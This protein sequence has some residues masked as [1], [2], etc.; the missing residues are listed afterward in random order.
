MSAVAEEITIKDG[1]GPVEQVRIPIPEGG[2][3]VV[4]T[5]DNG[6]GKSESL[7]AVESLLGKKNRLSKRDGALGSGTVEGLGVTLRVGVNVRRSGE[8]GFSTLDDEFSLTD[9][10]DPKEKDPAAADGRRIKAFVRAAD[11]DPDPSL[12][13]ELVGG[14]ETFLQLVSP[15]TI[16]K[17]DLVEMAA[18]IKRDLEAKARDFES[19]AKNEADHAKAIRDSIKD[20][21]L[22]NNPGE[23]INL[24]SLYQEAMQKKTQLEFS[25][26][27]AR[28]A[29]AKAEEARAKLAEAEKNVRRP[30]S[31]IST[32]HEEVSKEIVAMDN[33]IES[34]QKQLEEVTAKRKERNRDA[35]SLLQQLTDAATLEASLA[36]WKQSIDQA[37]NLES[38]TPEELKA[39]TDEIASIEVDIKSSGI[40]ER[41]I[42]QAKQADQ[43]QTLAQENADKAASLRDAAKATDEILSRIVSENGG[44]IK[45]VTGDDGKLRLAVQHQKRGEVYLSELSKGEKLKL[46]LPI[47]INSAIRRI[48]PERPYA[49]MVIPQELWEGLQP[50]NRAIVRDLLSGSNVVAITAECADGPLEA[51]VVE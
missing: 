29:A 11:V 27:L 3:I 25:A 23:A 32:E 40:I 49:V 51:H 34:L 8:L 36:G 30:S 45:V 16:E 24:Q 39:V 5:G 26:D 13:F 2:G 18:A 19:K 46:V 48:T 4:L 7:R 35:E 22:S 50:A 9:L 37:A 33:E 47:A 41:A 31:E 17:T 38:P 10:V 21:D 1:A 15:S 12:F 44:D 20:I 6:I 42:E 43:S 28:K 14:E